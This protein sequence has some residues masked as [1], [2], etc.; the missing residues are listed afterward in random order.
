MYLPGTGLWYS[1]K[2][3]EVA[4]P[5]SSGALS[6][7]VTMDDVPS[8][9]RGGHIMP[10]RVRAHPSN[11]PPGFWHTSHFYPTFH[12]HLQARMHCVIVSSTMQVLCNL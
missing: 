3:G 7:P 8:F 2:T 10:L 12:K 1:A 6:V 11:L 4:K 9:L 5:D